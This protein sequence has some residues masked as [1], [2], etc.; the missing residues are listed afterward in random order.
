MRECTSKIYRTS[1]SK[2]ITEQITPNASFTHHTWT[3]DNV[4]CCWIT[5]VM[6]ISAA[7]S[8][9]TVDGAV[10]RVVVGVTVQLVSYRQT[11]ATEN[12]SQ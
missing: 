10:R 5:G 12:H 7:V 11:V 3:A 2:N 6:S 4:A 9:D 1:R 8:S